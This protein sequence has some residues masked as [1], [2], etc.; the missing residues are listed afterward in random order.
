MLSFDSAVQI[1]RSL[2]GISEKDHFG[3]DAFYANK[4]IFATF[5]PDKNEVNVR[6]SPEEQMRYLEEPE[7]F[8][9]IDNAWGRQGWTT[10]LLKFVSRKSFES[11]LKAAWAHSA[12]SVPKK[13]TTG[14][15]TKSTKTK[16]RKKH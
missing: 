13:K 14:S 11:A 1:A 12:K 4:R 5:W 8:V 16:P 9:Q 3:S 10:V 15:F 6:L 2:E 7:A